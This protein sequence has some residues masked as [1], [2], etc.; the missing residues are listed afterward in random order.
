MPSN[1]SL[2]LGTLPTAPI[3]LMP[4]AGPLLALHD[5]PQ[6]AES[7]PNPNFLPSPTVPPEVIEG[8][9]EH[10]ANPIDMHRLSRLCPKFKA[11]AMY[12]MYGRVTRLL[13]EFGLANNREFLRLLRRHAVYWAG[14]GLLPALFP[15]YNAGSYGGRMEL[16]S[17]DRHQA[18]SPII[19]LLIS[20][21]F[22]VDKIYVG[23][24][25]V[26]TF[27]SGTLGYPYFGKTVKR[28]VRLTKQAAGGLKEVIVFVSKSELAGFLSI[29]EY[30]T[31]LMM[32]YVDG[33]NFHVFGPNIVSISATTTHTVRFAFVTNSTTVAYSLDAPSTTPTCVPSA[34]GT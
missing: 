18:L 4:G 21:G 25:E 22:G 15:D 26:E 7:H 13:G 6:C 28:I 14:P 34:H 31:T 23:H 3:S 30:P 9:L 20:S 12:V 11:L 8:I 33:I 17:P 19:N 32:V 27:A 24:R 2:T 29:V 5:C 16:H 10:V 1:A